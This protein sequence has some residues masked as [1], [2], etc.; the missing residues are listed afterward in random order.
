MTEWWRDA[1]VYQVY[2]RSFADADGDGLGDLRGIASRLPYLRELGVDA[3][4]IGPVFT[5]PQVDHGYDVADYRDIDPLFGTL[6]DMDALIEAAHALGVKVTLDLVPNH[7]SDQ[8]PWFR[9]AVAAGRGSPERSRYHFR[10]G[11]GPHGD[12]PPSNWRAVFGGSSWTRVTEP[13]G[14]PGQW[15]YHLFAAEQP[16][17]D[18][19]NPDVLAEFESIFRFWLDRGIDGFR[20]DVADGLTKD[21]SFPDTADGSAVIPKGIDSPVHDVYRALRRVL[22][23]YPGDRMAVI[24]TGADAETVAL[25][26]R[27]DE[28]PLA[29]HF[30]FVHASFEAAA[31]RAAIDATLAANAPVNAASTWV[32]DNHDT[33]RSVTRYGRSTQVSGAYVPGEMRVR[34]DVAADVEAGRRR[35]RAVA[36]LLLAVPG[37]AYLYQGQELGLP[38]VDDLP[39]AVLQDPIWERSGH[40]IRGRDGCRVPLPWSGDAPPFGFSASSSTWLPQPPSWSALTVDRQAADASSILSLYRA[41]LRLRHEHRALGRGELRRVVSGDPDVLAFDMVGSGET[42]RVVANFRSQPV[43][44]PAGEVLLASLPLDADSRL[45]AE[46]AAWILPAR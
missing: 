42:V 12:Q 46:A 19:A 22:A 39:E 32:T 38:N 45:P 40:A 25:F 2:P 8:H 1:V 4:W 9:A 11:R 3:I 26:L 21:P 15:Y 6:A 28:M 30:Q 36:M 16:D 35:A 7:T 33:T 5:S 17:L 18:W 20:I 31:F 37:A 24:E 23:S 41:A 34:D 27:P 10:D 14:T 13:D 29:F 43:S 44:L